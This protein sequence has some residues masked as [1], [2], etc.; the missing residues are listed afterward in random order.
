MNR[1]ADKTILVTGGNSG[2]G[3]AAA[4]AFAREGARVVITGRDQATLDQARDQIGAGTIALKN[5]QGDPGAA[6]ALA[7]VLK[8]KGI[9]LDAL[10]LNAGVARFAPFA[11]SDEALWDHTFDINVKGTYFTLQA[12]T[13][14]FRRGAAVVLNGSVSAHIGMS[15]TSVYAASKAALVSLAKTLSV[16]LLPLG[17]R[18]NVI[19]P[20]PIS[21]PL[22]G[23]LGLPAGQLD[24]LI[25]SVERQVPLKRFG[26]PQEVA[27]AVLYLS[28][29]ESGFI[30]GTELIIDGGLILL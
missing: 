30:V 27:S 18:V 21:T 3:L 10:F 23:R 6:R 13:P 1:F 12:L 22:H 29:P 20:G 7:T 17:V 25:A 15:S 28:S 9:T 16:E 2:M 5:D 19:S 11:D 14:L 4:I 24:E 8:E 26:T